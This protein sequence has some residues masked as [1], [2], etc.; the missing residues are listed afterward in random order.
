MLFKPSSV[1]SLFF[2]RVFV[3]NKL[4]FGKTSHFTFER[5]QVL[6][7]GNLWIPWRYDM[8]LTLLDLKRN[9]NYSIIAF[10][11]LN[12]AIQ[13]KTTPVKTEKE[14]CHSLVTYLSYCPVHPTAYMAL[15][16]EFSLGVYFLCVLYWAWKFLWIL[17]YFNK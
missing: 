15:A 1:P 4:L 13:G 14:L 2:S 3:I 10:F 6:K 17:M 12:E 7:T 9:F 8:I 16:F 5:S 11:K